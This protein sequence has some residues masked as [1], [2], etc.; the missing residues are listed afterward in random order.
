[1]VAVCIHQAIREWIGLNVNRQEVPTGIGGQL[2]PMMTVQISLRQL[3]VAVCTRRV[4]MGLPGMSVD[5][6]ETPIEGGGQ[7]PLMAMGL[8]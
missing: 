8:I 4:I 6:Q 7:L 1:M 3:M 5:R 2:P